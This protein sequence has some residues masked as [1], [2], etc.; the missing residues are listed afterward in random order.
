M[1]H[2]PSKNFRIKSKAGSAVNL[3]NKFAPLCSLSSKLGKLHSEADNSLL[4]HK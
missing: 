2:L 3:S 1:F 4:K